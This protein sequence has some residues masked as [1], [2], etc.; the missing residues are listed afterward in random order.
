MTYSWKTL[1]AVAAGAGFA[2]WFAVR[3][4]GPAAP[5]GARTERA[6]V[7]AVDTQAA[8]REA[9]DV[10]PP[11]P[12]GAHEGTSAPGSGARTA[13]PREQADAGED[14]YAVGAGDLDAL[15]AAMI[16]DRRIE[17]YLFPLDSPALK[18]PSPLQYRRAPG[19]WSAAHA[20]A[21]GGTR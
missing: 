10:A 19:F 8:P 2:G 14:A 12:A 17:K 13:A 18:M 9:G 20:A 11:Q 6:P 7:A 15:R 21:R 1:G 3:L 4:L 5:D 16:F